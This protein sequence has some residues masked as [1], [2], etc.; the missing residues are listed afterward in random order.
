M[1]RILILLTFIMLWKCAPRPL[2]SHPVGSDKAFY[3]INTVAFYNLENLFDTINDPSKND[4]ASPI[5]Q[6]APQIRG[7]VYKKKIRNMAKVISEIGRK[8]AKNSPAVIGVAEVENRSVLEDLVQTSYLIKKNYGIIHYNSPDRRGIDV[9]LLYQRKLFKPLSSSPHEV[10]IYD[11]NTPDKRY[12]TRD[13]L[14]VSGVLDQD[15]LHI[16]VNHWPSRY[17]GEKRSRPNREKAA[18]VNKNIVDSLQAV[19][20]YA[21]IIIMGDMNDDPYNNSIKKVLKAKA[22]QKDVEASGLFNPMENMLVKKGL[23]TLGYHDSWDLFDQIILSKPLLGKDYRSYQFFKAGIY[24]PSY[25]I[26]SHGRYKGYPYRSFVGNHFTGGYS[27]H[28][29]VYIYLIKRVNH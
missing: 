2:H 27:D 10:V 16:L 19:D 22:E 5:M 14:L 23:G 11:I 18:A 1:K 25:L 7:K 28:L 26:T 9:A 21:G 8:K 29:P 20:P 17:G 4:E 3:K 15:T 12:Y 24:N 6:L 13:V